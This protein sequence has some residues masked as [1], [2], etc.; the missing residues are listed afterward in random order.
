V[1]HWLL[2]VA[3]ASMLASGAFI[4]GV[5]PLSHRVL[6][7]IHVGSSAVLVAGLV[8][9]LAG[10]SS[11]RPLA[12][13]AHDLR[14]WA[15]NDTRWLRRAPRVYLGGGGELPAQGR[16]NAGQ[17]VN[18]RLVLLLLLLLYVTGI[19]ELRRY[20]SFLDPLGV[21]AGFHGLFAGAAAALVVGHMYLALIHPSTRH[22][23]RGITRGDVRRDWAEEHHPDWLE[24][25]DAARAGA[26][27]DKP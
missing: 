23:L 2:T 3:F 24:S 17:K 22:A 14:R 18:A 15:E 7:L 6:L 11:R 4:G 16:F 12:Q 19:G 10:R 8:A 13:T 21:V 27:S 20:A 5:G 25:V 1:A 26:R 9:L